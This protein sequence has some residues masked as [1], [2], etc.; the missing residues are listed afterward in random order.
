M[1]TTS[2]VTVRLKPSLLRN[3]LIAVAVGGVPLFGV[4]TWLGIVHGTL[5][6]V[7]IAFI[8][9][10]FAVTFTAWRHDHSY[11]RVL[12]R[13]VRKVTYASDRVIPVAD[14]DQIVICETDDSSSPDT[15]PQLLAL[16]A[17]GKRLFRMRG[18]YWS[19]EDMHVVAN[20]IGAPVAIDTAQLTPKQFYVK[21]RGAAYWYE[22]KPWLTVLG[23]AVAVAVAFALVLLMTTIAGA[24]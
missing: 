10:V 2:A 23:I 3:T 11:V 22:G 7:I 8:V 20:A 13:Q 14:V 15:V 12:E 6:L 1:T 24:F 5:V 21:Y 9:V 16:D 18:L 4:L 17:E 19:I